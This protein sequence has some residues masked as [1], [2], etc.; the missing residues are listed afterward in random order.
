MKEKTI[1]EQ[2]SL[3]LI[4]QMIQIAKKEQ[5]DSG[6]GW[7]LFGWLLFAASTVT[8][9]NLIFHW[10]DT[11]LFWNILGIASLLLLL[12][13]VCNSIFKRKKKQVKTYTSDLFEKLNTG[14]F[15][16]LSLIIIS[17]NAGLPPLKGFA[18]LLSLYG[19]WMLI[20]GASMNF[21]P[22]I[23][24]AY[25]TWALALAALFVNDFKWTMILHSVAILAGFIIPG[26]IAK[27]EF[28]KLQ[29]TEKD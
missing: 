19:F 29:K 1:T 5:K 11:F 7:I 12:F 27:K 14:F 25:I 26:Y 24:G 13:T 22:S 20:Y 8:Y 6:S 16:F 9:L 4:Q 3:L 23:T 28:E 10:V 15:I 2:E 18:I 21:K 17:M